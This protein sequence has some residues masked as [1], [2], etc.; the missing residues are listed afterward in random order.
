MSILGY[1]D[2]EAFLSSVKGEVIGK[3]MT[4]A[5]DH[6]YKKQYQYSNLSSTHLLVSPKHGKNALTM[7]KC[8]PLDESLIAFF[9]LYSGDGE[10]GIEDI[11]NPARIHCKISFSQREPHLVAFA[12]KQFRKLFGPDLSF[13]FEVG[14][15]SAYFFQGEGQ[16]L[17]S[18]YYHG[19]IPSTPSLHK[20]C[21]QLSAK[22]EAYLLE[23]RPHGL[24][25]EDC[26]AFH[27][28]H[29]KAMQD[30]LCRWKAAELAK[31]GITLSSKDKIV[32]SLRRPFK[33]GARLPGGSSRSDELK[34]QGLHGFGELFL[35]ILYELED[36]I[37]HDTISSP[38]GLIRWNNKP[39]LLGEKISLMDFFT[40]SPY[41]EINKQR[42]ILKKEGTLLSGQWP[43][44]KFLTLFPILQCDPLWCYAAGLY[45][46]EG[47]TPK[48]KLFSM[49]HKSPDKLSLKF[50]ST[51][52][53]S[54]EMILK[55]LQKLFKKEDCLH[56]WKIKVGSQY[57]EELVVIGLKCGVPMLR[58]GEHGDGKLRTM[59]ISV[60]LRDW[61]L[62]VIPCLKEYQHLFTHIEPTGAGLPRIDFSA[63]SSL[64]R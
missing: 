44:G 13:R 60:C 33:K 62:K 48:S 29:S 43:R 16:E 11:K 19:C 2:L 22:D 17:L 1:I 57:F 8:I 23:K 28:F 32:A 37:H 51:E 27:Y 50:T 12:V 9:G 40:H 53:D 7:K 47:S 24:N 52:N 56:S 45:L 46:A 35:K 59:E 39:S 15:D 25:N 4:D 6:N 14:E 55:S 41:G 5:K 10:K 31:V 21:P 18:Q 34:I 63:S 38:T 20:V 64:C 3:V 58:G 36:S 26:L 30:I 49:Y 54:I 42:P 61:A